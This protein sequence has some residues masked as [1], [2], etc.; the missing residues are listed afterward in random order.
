V[1]SSSEKG[2]CSL[3][4]PLALLQLS[5]LPHDEWGSEGRARWKQWVIG[6]PAGCLDKSFTKK[7][8]KKITPAIGGG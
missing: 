2:L 1:A 5:S 3:L 4:F 7:I 8:N 6:I